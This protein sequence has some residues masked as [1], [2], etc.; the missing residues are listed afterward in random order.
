LIPAGLLVTVP[1]P[2]P[3]LLTVKANCWI[4]KVAV[5]DC[6]A[7]I[8]TTQLPVPEHAP[9]QPANVDPADGEAVN[10]T[11]VPVS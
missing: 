11:D 4:L 8:V 9:L 5:T 6:A 7:L 1:V 2:V 10:V 3:A